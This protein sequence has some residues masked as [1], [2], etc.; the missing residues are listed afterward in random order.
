MGVSTEKRYS[1][2]GE[3]GFTMKQITHY[4]VMEA[5]TERKMV[6]R[7]AAIALHLSRRQ[8]QHAKKKLGSVVLQVSFMVTGGIHRLRAFPPS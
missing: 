2:K 5:L 1:M 8:V 4:S 6:T 3:V 7:K